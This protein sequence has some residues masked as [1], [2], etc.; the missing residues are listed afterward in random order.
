M[1]KIISIFIFLLLLVGCSL[2]NSPTSKV[3]EL[4][5]KYQRLDSD[6]RNGI[7]DVVKDENLTDEQSTRYNKLLEKVKSKYDKLVK[8]RTE[9]NCISVTEDLIYLIE[10]SLYFLLHLS[11]YSCFS[12]LFKS[13]IFNLYLNLSVLA[14]LNYPSFLL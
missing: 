13:F 3:E 7:N 2:S 14:F 11:R 4:F 9:I 8:Y 10:L 5:S 12:S 6:V 1:K